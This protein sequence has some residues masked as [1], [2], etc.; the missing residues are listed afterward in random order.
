MI[1]NAFGMLRL[2]LMEVYVFDGV[3]SRAVEGSGG[4][5]YLGDVS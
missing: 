3:E 1:E 2:P 5:G 4:D